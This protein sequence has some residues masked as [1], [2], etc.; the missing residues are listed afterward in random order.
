MEKSEYSSTKLIEKA[1]NGDEDAINE[2]MYLYSPFVKKIVRYYG[3]VLNK[4]DKE[5]IF[6][7]GLL[8]LQRAILSF[9]QE[10]GKSFEDFAFIAVRNTVLDFLKKRKNDL[11]VT[12]GEI[13]KSDEHDFENFLFLKEEIEEFAKKLSPFEKEVFRLWLEGYRIRDISL[14][15]GKPYKSIDNAVQRIKKRLRESFFVEK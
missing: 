2:L 6:I 8:A 12:Y 13:V 14:R 7:E 5:D 3:I 9:D 15:I 4:E 1:K 10:K 11:K